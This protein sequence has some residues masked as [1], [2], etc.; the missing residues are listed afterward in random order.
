[1]KVRILRQE[2]PDTDSYW[3]AFVYDGPEDN[4]VAG[5][6]DYLNFHDDILDESGRKTTRI[7]WDCS[8]MQGVCGACAMVINEVPVLACE[9]FLK[10]LKGEEITLRPL[11]KFPVIRDLIVDRSLIHENLR[12]TNVFIGEYRPETLKDPRSADRRHEHHYSVSKCLRCGL[13][14]EVCP[15]YTDGGTFFGAA[16]ANDCY[17]VSTRNQTKAKEFRKVYGEHFGNVCSKA[18][19]CMEV[20][21]MH[22]PTIAS[23][24]KMNR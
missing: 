14:L 8:C 23:M 21:P 10:S 13:C 20:C 9:T 18:L 11:R 2:A 24:A 5:L 3:E 19:S 1:M 22:I 6:L 16:F 7:S 15:N 12:K 4:T 17:L